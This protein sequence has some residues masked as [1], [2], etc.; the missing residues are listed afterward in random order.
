MKN[1]R[2]RRNKAIA[3][4]GQFLGKPIIRTK[5]VKYQKKPDENLAEK[6]AK[7]D[8][9]YNPVTQT[10]EECDY[11]KSYVKLLAL[12]PDGRMICKNTDGSEII[13]LGEEFTDCNW[14]SYEEFLKQ[15]MMN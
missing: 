3:Y 12:S 4:L 15:K 7:K 14:I 8:P 10:R 5:N 11:T 13:I 9:N 6:S 2:R 1:T